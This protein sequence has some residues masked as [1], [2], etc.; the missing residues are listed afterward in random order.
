MPKV[1]LNKLNPLTLV[2]I[3]VVVLTLAVFERQMDQEDAHVIELELDDQALD[4]GVEVVETLALDA[5][6]RQEG[7]ALLAHDGHEIVDR[8]LAVLALVGRV[9]PECLGDVLSL[10]EHAAAD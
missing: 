5:R 10:V 2:L 1:D 4:A 7:V 6:R 3:T 8:G 9:V